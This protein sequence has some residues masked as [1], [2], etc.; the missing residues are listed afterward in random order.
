MER[1]LGK[2][3][4][5]NILTAAA[6]RHPESPAIYCA[7]TDRRFN[8]RQVEERTNRLAQTLLGLS[9][10]K[11]DVVAF[12]TSNRAEIVEIYFALA[13]TGIVGLP[14]NYRLAA[15]E[16]LEL[17]RAM[18]A[19]GLIYEDR[20]ASV[21]EQASA[22]TKHLIQ[23]GGEK[24]GHAL[25]YEGLLAA[26]PA[27][28]PEIEIDEADPFYFNLTSGTTGLP[29]SYLLT[30]YNNS[31]LGS[32]F[33]A[34]D[35][36]RH[37]V[38]MTVFPAF[39]RVGFAWI[40]GSMLYG[41][42][43]VLANFEPNEVLR[44]IA[45]ERVTIFN[46]VPTMAAMMLP[47]QTAAKHDL[48]SVRGIVFAGA[49][50]PES[51]RAQTAAE[52][53]PNIYEYYGMQET[54]ALVVSTPEDRKRRSDSVGRAITFAEVRIVDDNG[55][56]LEP[57]QVG[58]IVGRSP[59]AVTA[60]Y[61]NPA[62]SAETFRDGW[63]H[64]GDLG[65]LDAE[66]YLTIRGRKKDMIVTGGQNVYAAE[67]EEILLK[68]P[69]VADCAVFGLPDNLW[70]ERVTALVVTEQDMAVTPQD[71]DAFCRQHLAGFKTPKEFIVESEALPRTPTGK[72][73]KFLLVERFTRGEP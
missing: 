64:T 10:R 1:S 50:L 40:A 32:M 43:H 48:G 3:V 59:N 17:V 63:I 25:D 29:K 73:Q 41:I 66:G 22:T 60:Y 46:L 9:F 21:A 11:G 53:C 45:A 72:V 56:T 35:L 31:T 38:T 24:T 47:A 34:L 37:D 4:V 33:Q 15:A 18:G 7:A 27:T 42:P 30:Q 49:M 67:V 57:D 52:L 39:G 14:L 13:R 20:F 69:G 55:R 28:A 19:T 61:Q 8:Y 6:I 70:G 54:G 26:A 51:I 65:S 62:K 16:I 2:M 71:L 68:C 36:S 58:E 44:L 5:G 12:L 23:F